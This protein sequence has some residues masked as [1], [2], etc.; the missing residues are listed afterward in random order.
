LA[1][2]SPALR[3]ALQPGSDFEPIPNPRPGDWLATHD[4]TG[5]TFDEFVASRPDTRSERRRTIYLQPFGRFASGAMLERL[6]EFAEA[7]FVLPVRMLPA[8]DTDVVRITRR[9]N[10][11]TG[12][13]QLLTG[14]VLRLL[15]FSLPPDAHCL[16]AITPS[17][18]YPDPAWNFVFG[19]ASLRDRVGVYSFARY[20]PS[21]YG[22]AAR[23]AEQL[24]LQRSCKVLAHETSHMFGV[25]HCIFFHCLMNGS[26]HLA[27]SDA[28][29]LHLC[30]V[31]LRKLHHSIGFDVERRYRRLLELSVAAGV[32][33]EAAWLERQLRRLQQSRREGGGS[34]AWE[35]K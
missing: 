22:E 15:A 14:D 13:E 8:V 2:L 24:L 1:G 5:Q 25:R 29:P 20:D 30:P 34:P 16:L 6:R 11:R 9:K 7:F 21:F 35:S 3:C 32:A 33:A 19:Q 4:E 10:P 28:R 26:N 12:Q 17:D 27:E 31:D 18:L 23:N